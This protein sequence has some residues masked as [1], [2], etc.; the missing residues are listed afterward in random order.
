MSRMR[1]SDVNE[2]ADSNLALIEK[3]KFTNK[4]IAVAIVASFLLHLVL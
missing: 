4:L 2:K 1:I 3:Q